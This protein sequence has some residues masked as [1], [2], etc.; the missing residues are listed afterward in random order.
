MSKSPYNIRNYHPTDFNKY[1]LLNIEAEKLEPAGRCVSP[2][3]VAERLGRPNYSPERDL[4][5][6]GI[7]GSIVGYM[8][9]IPEL[10]IGRVILDCW[11]HTEHRR[12]GL[13]TELLSYAI[14]RAKKLEAKVAHVNIAE[15]NEVAER[16][17]SKL[18]FKSVRRF[19]KLRLALDK[20][21]RQDIDQAVL[22]CRHL[23]CGEENK[24]TKIQNRCFAGT[25][26]YK[27]NP[28]EEIIY[29]TNLSNCSPEDI[30]LTYD[31][32]KVFGYC[33]TEITYKGEAANG[34]REGRIYMLGVDPDYRGMGVGK[35]VLLGGLNYLRSKG[36]QVAE[37]TV[38]SENKV[39]CALYWSVGFEVWTS[40]LWY[41][42]TIN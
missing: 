17:L 29:R 22:E 27:P 31:G 33:W 1:V 35:K 13:A 19:L 39:A 42:K 9:V 11:V 38:D 12:K 14:H 26:G 18:G 24:L 25:W 40:T 7:A 3:V 34:E 37:L 30:V 5:I 16:V 10:T 2:K 41:E 20:V 23:R 8:D 36:I 28:V 15:D 21:R 4:F 6:V 32:D